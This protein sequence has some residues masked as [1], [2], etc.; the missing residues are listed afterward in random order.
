MLEQVCDTGVCEKNTPP[1]KKTCEKIGFQST[2]AGAGQQFLLLDC[3]A[4]ARIEGVF[5]QTPVLLSQS[6]GTPL[7]KT[8]LW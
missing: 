5:V 6:T 1:E 4:R 7:Q 8:P 3:R 2:K